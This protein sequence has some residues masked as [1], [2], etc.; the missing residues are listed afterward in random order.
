MGI[1]MKK[2]SYIKFLCLGVLLTILIFMDQVSKVIASSALKG[3]DKQIIIK[4]LLSF[5]YLENRGAAW[6]FM[7]GKIVFLTVIT[8]FF[9]LILF[10]IIYKIERVL[11]Q[12]NHKKSLFSFIQ[13]ILVL[14]TAGALGNLIDR[15]RLEYVVDFIQ[16]EFIEFPIF[17][18]ADCYVTVSAFVLIIVLMFFLKEEDLKE[19]K[20]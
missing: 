7:S 18:V 14:L 11:M 4:N 10:V 9:T 6:G 20:G 13:F 12:T 16:F 8:I 3:K 5:E 2:Q 15:L 1:I 19:I 17:N